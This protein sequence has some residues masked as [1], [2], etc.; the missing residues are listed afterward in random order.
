LQPAQIH[1]G[2]FSVRLY[3]CYIVAAMNRD[4]SVLFIQTIFA[5]YGRIDSGISA[6]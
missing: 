3:A 5:P 4:L 6:K 2:G 1:L